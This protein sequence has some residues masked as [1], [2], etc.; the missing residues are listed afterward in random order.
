MKDISIK[1]RKCKNALKDTVFN[2]LL[3]F[4]SKPGR[5]IGNEINIV[6]KDL[7]EIDLRVALVFPDVYEVG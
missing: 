3:P 5:Y 7:S 4:V 1:E 6:K 2:Q